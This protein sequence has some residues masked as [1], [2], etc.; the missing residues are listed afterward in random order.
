MDSK[1]PVKD[2]EREQ[3]MQT[4]REDLAAQEA[5]RERERE[6]E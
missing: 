3:E 5:L 1:A 2:V 4:L 6:R